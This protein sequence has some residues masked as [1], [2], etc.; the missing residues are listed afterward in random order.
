MFIFIEVKYFNMYINCFEISVS[1]VDMLCYFFL[2]YI[3]WLFFCKLD[4]QTQEGEGDILFFGILVQIPLWHGS[5][6]SLRKKS[7]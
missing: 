6:L 7:I 1:I 2:K 5:V 4:I 3:L